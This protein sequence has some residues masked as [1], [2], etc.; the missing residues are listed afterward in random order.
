MKRKVWELTVLDN[1]NRAVG[2]ESDIFYTTDTEAFLIFRLTDEDFNPATATL[3]L[4]NT[5]DKSV[6]SESVPVIDKEIEW[7][8]FEDAIAHSG[9]WQAQLVYTQEK[10]GKAEHYTSQVVQFDIQSHL[11]TGRQ[12]SLVAIEDWNTF[13]STAQDLLAQLEEEAGRRRSR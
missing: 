3:T 1:P 8:M 12:P 7:E 4:V 13:M 2:G 9:N 6:I 5:S 10:D 11:L